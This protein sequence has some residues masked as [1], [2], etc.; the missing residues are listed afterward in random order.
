MDSAIAVVLVMFTSL[1]LLA[2][3]SARRSSVRETSSG[4]GED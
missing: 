3:R 1:S 2:R 4:E